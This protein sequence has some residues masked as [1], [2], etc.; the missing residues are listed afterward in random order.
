ML[1]VRDPAGL[2]AT[3]T[4]VVTPG[5]TPPQPTISAPM[6]TAL[7]GVGDVIT[8]SGGA[9]DAESG[10]LG[11]AALRWSLILHHCV[12][13]TA[14]HTHPIQEY[15]GVTGGTVIAPDHEYPSFL[16]FQLTA[17][18]PGGLQATTSVQIAAAPVQL[19][20]VTAPTGL[21][22]SVGTAIGPAPFTYTAIRG[23]TTSITAA[24]QALNGQTYEFVSWS[25]G[26]A[27]VHAV[28][29]VADTAYTA[30]FR[31]VAT[32]TI[33]SDAF[34]RTVVDGWGAATTGGTYS[35]FGPAADFDV[36]GG[37]GTIALPAPSASRGAFLP[38]TSAVDIDLT[39]TVRID[40]AVTGSGL[41]VYAVSR[42]Q[43]SGAEYR[44]Q[45]RLPAGGAVQ[46]QASRFS[47]TAETAIGNLVTVP[48]LTV[49]PNAPLQLRTQV[50]GTNPTTIRI[51]VWPG[52]QAEP[53]VWHLRSPTAPPASRAPGASGFRVHLRV[54]D[55]HARGGR[56]RRPLGHE[57]PASASATSASATTSAAASASASAS[58]ASAAAATTATATTTTTTTHNLGRRRLR[59]RRHRWLGLGVDRRR[60]RARRPRRE[61]RRERRR[62]HHRPAHC[63]VDPYGEP[64]GERTGCRRDGDGAD[65]QGRDGQRPVHLRRLTPATLGRRIP[66]HAE[67]RGEWDGGRAAVALHRHG[68]ERRRAGRHHPGPDTHD[69][70]QL[71]LRTQITGA[72]P[73]T[74]RIRAWPTTVAE[75][76][77]WS[78]TATDSTAA[79]QVTGA[80]GLLAYL[81]S[82]TTNA[83]VLLTVD[84]YTVT[85]P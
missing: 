55:E 80:L 71:R 57:R 74:I 34:G 4:V 45:I 29:P 46:V 22:L 78:I 5:N 65:R 30:T 51:R 16:E 17:T 40:K 7:W 39:A 24:T 12:T 21:T 72:N 64:A 15:P 9:T 18:D 11:P 8:F 77:T 62:R 59:P 70:H 2:E 67:A 83:P 56:V 49:A 81:S 85:I 36:G 44:S 58:A 84:D 10:A 26:G 53:T 41:Y 50:T 43:P 33:A 69:G 20:F 38:A 35:L 42:R 47:G 52:G 27:P 19:Q 75:P 6:A 73:T 60:V 28:Q 79:L 82:S 54:R 48:G 37:R 3:D 76:T 25:D 66:H 14:C 63:V 23:G 32:A 1:R 13:P 31:A 61:L 68:R